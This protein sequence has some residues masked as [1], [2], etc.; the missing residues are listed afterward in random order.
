MNTIIQGSQIG[1]FKTISLSIGQA[2]KANRDGKMSKFLVIGMKNKKSLL[3]KKQNV[4]LFEEDLSP[5]I[6]E[7][8]MKYAKVSTDQTH[9]GS[10]DVSL[11]DFKASQ[12]F[13]S[14]PDT[15]TQ[16]LEF[17]GGCF[18][19]YQ[20]EKGP[21]YAND[22]QGN[23]VM[24]GNNQQVIRNSV[25]VFVQIDF[26]DAEGKTHYIEPFSKNAQ[27]ARM[28][29]RFFRT[30]VGATATQQHTFDPA[31]L[32]GTQQQTSQQ[33]QQAPQHPGMAAAPVPPAPGTQ[34]PGI[35]NGNAPF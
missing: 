2:K 35:P 34:A 21:C 10:F 25:A 17:P 31:S 26:I 32:M 28:E 19:E 9:Q 14:D 7:T 29:S 3:G 8:L 16:L 22:A 11:A 33:Q 13:A 6:F 15:W 18:E 30:P 4:I 5:E 27:G 1:A 12:E 23:M 24:D 20:F